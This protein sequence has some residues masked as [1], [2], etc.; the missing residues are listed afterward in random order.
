[1][2]SAEITQSSGVSIL[3]TSTRAFIRLHWHSQT[4]AGQLISVP[5]K[6]RLEDL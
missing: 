3:D 1:V 6:Y 2:T 5:V 4:Y